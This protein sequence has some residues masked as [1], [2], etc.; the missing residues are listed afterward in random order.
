M[1]RVAFRRFFRKR[2]LQD[3]REREQ[4]RK[5][6]ADERKLRRAKARNRRLRNQLV[7]LKEEAKSPIER[8]STGDV[9]PELDVG[10]PSYILAARL[11]KRAQTNR[12][13]V[14]EGFHE[15]IVDL[16][17]KTAGRAFAQAHGIKVPEELGRWASPSDVDWETLP[18]SFVLKSSQGGG[19]I[20]VYP[21]VR[22]DGD[23]FRDC[24]TDELVT[25]DEVTARLEAR[26][27]ET[28]VYFAEEFLQSQGGEEG[29]MPHDVKVFCFYGEAAYI[30]V[31]TA[32]WSRAKNREPLARSFLAD[33][34]EV[35]GIRPLMTGSK[36]LKRPNNLDE[37]IR[38][39]EKL[40]KSIRRPL[41]RIDVYT[42]S[43]GVIFG[44][45]TQN[46]GHSPAF[47]P[48]WDERLGRVY[49]R[50]YRRLLS[51]LAGEGVFAVEFGNSPGSH[52]K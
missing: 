37:I 11:H 21:L 23:T 33:G 24:L 18:S 43:E 22:V 34:A 16:S 40:S 31:R 20:N 30:E 28:S 48:E 50:A 45:V 1:T 3:T 5:V 42:T 29:E 15:P 47:L 8:Q 39:C 14:D 19:G 2:G 35:T 17:P 41:Q 12:I 27:K 13:Y 9:D 7:V 46:P 4:A 36:T 49:E 44:E 52:V 26:D 32:D 51:D 6:S 10:K 38:T 25:A